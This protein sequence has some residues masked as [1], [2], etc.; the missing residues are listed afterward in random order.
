[1][2]FSLTGASFLLMIVGGNPVYDAPADLKFV[3]ALSKVPLR[4]HTGLYNDETAEEC[5]W[6]IPEAHFLES[7]GDARAYDG[8]VS[9]IQPMIQP[10]DNGKSPAEV[11]AVLLNKAGQTGLEIAREQWKT[12]MGAN[13][14]QTWRQ[15]LHDGIV[16]DSA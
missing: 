16:P 3:E 14:E 1:M 15:V 13:F 7:W 10:L 11:L 8:T 6:H 9:I 5:H 2:T 4:V 12:R